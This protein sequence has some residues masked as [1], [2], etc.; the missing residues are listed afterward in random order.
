VSV[1]DPSASE[2][3]EGRLAPCVPESA[4]T[5]KPQGHFQ[6][7][8]SNF[9]ARQAR[10]SVRREAGGGSRRAEPML[11]AER[12]RTTVSAGQPTRSLDHVLTSRRECLSRRPARHLA[13]VRSVLR[14]ACIR[15]PA[16]V[17]SRVNVH[18]WVIAERGGVLLTGSLPLAAESP[19]GSRRRRGREQCNAVNGW[20]GGGNPDGKLQCKSEGRTAG[21]ANKGELAPANF[22]AYFVGINVFEDST[23]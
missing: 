21:L 5:R 14:V 2:R 19:C 6:P 23:V 7:P 16:N 15:P 11:A 8:A 17:S 9:A 12:G 22:S 20:V 4:V 3:L 18:A 13:L 1:L 10:A